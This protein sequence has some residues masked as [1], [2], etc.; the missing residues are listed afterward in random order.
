MNKRVKEDL[1]ISFLLGLLAVIM[2]RLH[3]VPW[4]ATLTGGAIFWLVTYILLFIDSLIPPE[5]I[6][7]LW[8]KK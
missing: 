1:G 4:D 8:R 3:D 2:G 7:K 6:D 5:A